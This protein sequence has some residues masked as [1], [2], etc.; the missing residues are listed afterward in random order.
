MLIGF[1]PWLLGFAVMGIVAG[2]VLAYTFQLAH[3][4]EG[5][6]FDT[7]GIDDKL[8]ENEWAVHQVKTTANF[9]PGNKVITW[10]VGGLNYQVEHHLFPRISHIH[11]PAISKIVRAHCEQF[12]I[13]YHSF[14]KLSQA[15]ASHMRTMKKLGQPQAA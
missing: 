13:P 2:I 12:N 5:P 4:V 8:I 11:Y 1:I 3:A 14:P 6:E 15:L 10:M 9:S 7:V